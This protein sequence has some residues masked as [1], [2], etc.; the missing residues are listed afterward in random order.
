MRID[1]DT[2]PSVAT[3][4]AKT[5]D[6]L[7]TGERAMVARL[8]C[9]NRELRNK[10]LVMGLVEGALVEVSHVAPLGDPMNIKLLGFQL[11]LRL[12]EAAH[13]FVVPQ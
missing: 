3:T 7:R 9:T 11:S 2:V 12:S 8:A 5:L 1:G 10:L 4:I 13:V 6:T